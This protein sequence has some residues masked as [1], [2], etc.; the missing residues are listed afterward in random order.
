MILVEPH[1]TKAPVKNGNPAPV[2][3]AATCG[4]ER[5]TF[6]LLD[7]PVLAA[8]LAIGK[9]AYPKRMVTFAAMGS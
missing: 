4:G 6:S 2:L 1:K 5:R 9:A 7:C 8:A 3:Y